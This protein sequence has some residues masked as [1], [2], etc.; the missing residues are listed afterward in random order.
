MEDTTTSLPLAEI[1]C[2]TRWMMHRNMEQLTFRLWICF[3]L[4]SEFGLA[5]D[6]AFT[7]MKRTNKTSEEGCLTVIYFD[8]GLTQYMHRDD[9][10][11]RPNAPFLN[12]CA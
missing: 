2:V 1:V 12:I 5:C 3:R 10:R 7:I 9:I 4:F 6:R 8:L 11:T